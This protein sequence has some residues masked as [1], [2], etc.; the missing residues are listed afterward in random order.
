MTPK[1]KYIQCKTTNGGDNPVRI[2]GFIKRST[3]FCVL[4]YSN[5]GPFE[6]GA[7]AATEFAV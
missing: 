3:T 5:W 7:L 6:E 1:L 4:G 2:K